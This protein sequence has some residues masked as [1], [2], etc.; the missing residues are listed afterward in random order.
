MTGICRVDSI[1][2]YEGVG[3]IIEIGVE[4]NHLRRAQARSK[5][6]DDVIQTPVRAARRASIRGLSKADTC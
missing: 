6:C 1:R 3:L 2:A 5:S 4:V